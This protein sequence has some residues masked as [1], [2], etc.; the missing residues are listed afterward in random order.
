[1]EGLK[2]GLH[3]YFVDKSK[4]V[5]KNIEVKLENIAHLNQ[6]D[7]SSENM[8]YFHKYLPKMT[9]KF[10]Q[11]IYH[12]KDDTYRS[13]CHLIQN[14]DIVLLSGDKDSS[15]VVMNKKDYIL[16]VDNKIDEGIQQGKYEWAN[17]KTHED[18]EKFQHFLYHNF[19]TIQ[20]I[21]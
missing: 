15:V 21:L 12:T 16:K 17:H 11:N 4:S 6:K 3:H 2:Y 7:V 10:T 5:K 20:K 1:M 18:L 14:N 9:N 13:L 19:R 8:K